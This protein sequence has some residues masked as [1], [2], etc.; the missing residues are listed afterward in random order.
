MFISESQTSY[1]VNRPSRDIHGFCEDYPLGRYKFEEEANKG[2][3][4]CRR[5]W[6]KYIGPIERW[7]SCNPWEGHFGAVV[8]PFC[9]PERLAII[10]YIFE[11]KHP[12]IVT[13][14]VRLTSS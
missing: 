14:I 3:S 4:Q 5:D 12:V 8:L 11:C 10:S 9:R 7:G 2:S 1:L 13:I 6:T